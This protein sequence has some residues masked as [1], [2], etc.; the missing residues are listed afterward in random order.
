[1]GEWIELPAIGPHHIL[2]AQYFKHALTGDLESNV[3]TF[4]AFRGREKHYLKAQ[5]VR[6]IHNCEI[7]PTGMYK[8]NDENGKYFHNSATIIE[9]EPEYVLPEAKEDL[10]KLENW[11]HFNP[12]ILKAGRTSHYI[13]STLSEDKREE[14]KTDL[15]DKDP[16]VE[17]LKSVTEDK[18]RDI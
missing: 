5:L 7:V 8:T 6:M 11:S 10:G 15:E 14:L 13:P 3:S 4:P 12:C 9:I 18:R 17:R 16:I 2:S 1:M